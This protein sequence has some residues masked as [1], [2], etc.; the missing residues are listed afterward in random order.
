M[1]LIEDI[2]EAVS[3]YGF[4]SELFHIFAFWR[5]EYS[6]LS[7]LNFG[8]DSDTDCVFGLWNCFNFFFLHLKTIDRDFIFK[9][10]SVLTILFW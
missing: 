4:E 3:Q 6:F 5:Y 1:V 9:F 10:E 7:F 2:I 8:S